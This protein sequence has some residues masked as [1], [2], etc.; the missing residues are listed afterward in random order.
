MERKLYSSLETIE[1]L[2]LFPAESQEI[3]LLFKV[4][5]QVILDIS[6][7]SLIMQQDDSTS[8]IAL[9]HQST[10]NFKYEVV[11]NWQHDLDSSITKDA[12]G[13]LFIVD[14][15]GVKCEDIGKR[16]GVCIVSRKSIHNA[17]F[18]L[19]RLVQRELPMHDKRYRNW[20]ETLNGLPIAQVPVNALVI[21]DTHLFG[22]KGRFID[23]GRSNLISLLQILLPTELAT[24]FHLLL[25]ASNRAVPFDETSFATF[26]QEIE[27]DLGRPYKLQIG[28]I[29]RPEGGKER[30][31]IVGNY[32]FCTSQHG[33]ACFKNFRPD[34]NNDFNAYGPFEGANKNGFDLPALSMSTELKTAKTL[35][36]NNKTR[37]EA[38]GSRPDPVR[39]FLGYFD[40][41]LLSL[42]P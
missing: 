18:L 32:Y 41:R 34:Y 38:P 9:L 22:D 13:A 31:S 33:F 36:I 27:T 29:T 12:A 10:G 7:E 42:V 11:P 8:S 40:N 37:E 24:D 16:F 28:L 19:Q 15:D 14:D 39:R 26:S 6:Y 30:R 3:D 17:D 21:T 1:E 4:H 35:L 23:I 2:V 25:V 20:Q 5:S